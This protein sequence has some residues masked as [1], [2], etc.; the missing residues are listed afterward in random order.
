MINVTGLDPLSLGELGVGLSAL[1][2][3]VLLDV[4]GRWKLV[5]VLG[6][7]TN[8]LDKVV[9]SDSAIWGRGGGGLKGEEKLNKI[10][11]F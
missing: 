7:C 10:D 8:W 4:L 5:G 3:L 9:F 2:S 1:A 11:V 6:S